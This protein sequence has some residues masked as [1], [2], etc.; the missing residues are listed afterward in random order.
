M[1]LKGKAA[2]V[3]IGETP[4]D[5]LGGKPGEPRRSTAEYLSRAVRLALADAGLTKKDL[6]GQGLAAIYTTN[7]SQPF[8]PEEAANILGLAP[9]VSLAGG[10]GGASAV[11]LLGHAAAMI[12]SGVVDLVLVVSAAAPFSERGRSRVE[13]ADTRDFEMPFGVMGPNCKISFVMSRYMHESGMTADH[14]GKIAVTARYHATL[15]PDAYLRK[16]LTLEEYK[17]SRLISDPIRLY[18]CVLPAN[19]GKAYIM[20]SPARA[21]T[22]SQPPVY[23]QGWGE[24][25]NASA[26]P[27]SNANPL[28]TGITDSGK[29]AFAMAGLA[30]GDIDFLGLYDDYVPIVM[31]QIEDLGFCAKNDREFFAR[32][33]FTIK[34]DLPI[35]TGGGMINCG[36]PSTTG[37]M[38]HV[39]EAVRQ[40]RGEGGARQVAGAKAGLVTGLGAVNYGKNFGCTAAAILGSE[41]VRSEK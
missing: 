1:S 5:R 19:G 20:A 38:L 3:G 41:K 11:S 33:D 13:P 22:L 37:G 9:A 12:D 28:I 32:T 6:D 40:L 24:R 14:F 4:V 23:L 36:Q 2:I 39:I 7:H 35:Q 26:G 10:N 25:N 31:L 15:N 21:K 30:P 17:N 34:G 27:R 29:A 16:P 8:W 18:D